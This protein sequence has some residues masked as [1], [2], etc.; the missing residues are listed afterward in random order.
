MLHTDLHSKEVKPHQK[1]TKEEFVKNNRGINGGKDLPKPFL[2]ALYDHVA[3][4]EWVLE[5][6]NERYYAARH[7]RGRGSS[8][9]RRGISSPATGEQASVFRRSE[10]FRISSCGG[11]RREGAW[12]DGSVVVSLLSRTAAALPRP[13]GYDAASSLFA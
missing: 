6:E 12:G 1:M 13:D 9:E 5:E 11:S 2:E 3:K 8:G 7:A 10:R 4:E